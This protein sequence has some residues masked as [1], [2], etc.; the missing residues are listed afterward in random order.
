MIWGQLP[1]GTA[2][3]GMPQKSYML[4]CGMPGEVVIETKTADCPHPGPGLFLTWPLLGGTSCQTTSVTCGTILW[5]LQDRYVQPGISLRTVTFFSFLIPSL[6]LPAGQGFCS[7]HWVLICFIYFKTFIYY[8]VVCL[9]GPSSRE[10]CIKLE[11]K[12]S[13]NLS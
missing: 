10:G 6:T 5:R 8:I 11:N 1:F 13:I 4:W 7:H 2:S 9:P 12:K 3:P